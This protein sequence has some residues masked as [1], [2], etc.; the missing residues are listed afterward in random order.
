VTEPLIRRPKPF[1]GESLTSYVYRLA[2][3]CHYLSPDWVVKLPRGQGDLDVLADARII[4]RLSALT[5]L[6]SEDVVGLTAFGCLEGG[7][8]DLDFHWDGIPWRDLVCTAQECKIC[9]ECL[10]E[11][12]YL[13]VHW[14]LRPVT[15]CPKHTKLLVSRC[16]CGTLLTKRV[17]LE[18]RCRCGAKVTD[19]LAHNLSDD[20][21]SLS[22]LGFISDALGMS[23]AGV[24]YPY[25]FSIRGMSPL[26]VL[27]YLEG[28][29]RL[30]LVSCSTPV[31]QAALLSPLTRSLQ[32]PF[33]G[34]NEE[35]HV[36][37]RGAY[38]LLQDWPG[39]F[40]RLLRLPGPKD[41]GQ[42]GISR[43]IRSNNYWVSS[44]MRIPIKS[45]R[46][47]ERQVSV[48]RL[49]RLLGAGPTMVNRLVA[50]GRLDTVKEAGVVRL[51]GES[52]EAWLGA[53]PA[54]PQ[55][56]GQHNLDRLLELEANKLRGTLSLFLDLAQSGAG[57]STIV[58]TPT[59]GGTASDALPS[60]I[61]TLYQRGRIDRAT[62]IRL[63]EALAVRRTLGMEINA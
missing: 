56:E 21:D 25:D 42:S 43:L 63:A 12:A 27:A 48:G 51:S 26:E 1:P 4:D 57:G 39:S 61:V 30:L 29:A 47:P 14:L 35:R 5:L 8:R 58:R 37:Y 3:A 32:A 28:L 10:K 50:D 15:A 6:P 38:L 45:G 41:G 17:C 49:C 7:D 2:M 46:C 19:L 13:R 54:I 34:T 60:R 24:V 52:C 20:S 44:L 40:R 23:R 33:Y 18:N 16:V 11:S 31:R 59:S 53:A 36:V 62:A 55:V 22:Y 9:P